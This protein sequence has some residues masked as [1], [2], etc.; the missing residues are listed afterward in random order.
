MRF[1]TSVSGLLLL[2]VILDPPTSLASKGVAKHR[3]VKPHTKAVLPGRKE[4][5]LPKP[6]NNH[7]SYA[8]SYRGGADGQK[9]A[10]TGAVILTLIE[11]GMNKIFQSKGIKF[12]AALGGCI[13]LFFSLL[14][15]DI[16]SPGLG[17]S[18]FASLN[19]AAILLA[20]WLPVFF[21]PGLAMLPLAPSVGSGLEV[22]LT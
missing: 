21:V 14:L 15:A 19:P 4:L 3:L 22:G 1:L 13:S 20:K 18:I 8:L 11:R 6:F 16:I 12:P 10:I 7:G 2:A 17:E 5:K 9:D